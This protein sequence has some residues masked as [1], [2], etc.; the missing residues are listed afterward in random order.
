MRGTARTTIIQKTG[1]L[2]CI[3]GFGTIKTAMRICHV[4]TRMIVG[5][6]Q[7]NTLATVRGLAARGHEVTLISGPAEAEQG[8]LL[9]YTAPAAPAFHYITLP[10]LVRD[11]Q[12]ARDL[13]AYRALARHFGATPYDVIHTHSSKAGILGRLAARRARARGTRVVHTIHGLAFDAYQPWLLKRVYIGLERGC[14]RHTDKLVSVCDAMTQQALAAGVGTPDQYCTVYSGMDVA[15]FRA[16]RAGG[17]AWRARHGIAPD[18]LVLLCISRLFPMK[19]VEDFVDVVGA[20]QRTLPGQVVGVIVGDGPLRSQI[21]AQACAAGLAPSLVFA[22][23]VA[24]GEIPAWVG[25]ADALVHASLREGLARTLVQALAGGKP[26]FAYD[27]G[28]AREIVQQDGN[29][30]LA[31]AGAC[32]ALTAHVQRFVGDAMYRARV[33]AG[34]QQTDVARFDAAHMVAALEALYLDF[35]QRP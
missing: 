7:E 23:L 17:T 30:A 9:D 33:T 11:I 15:S 12:P 3:A 35:Q 4:I 16:A 32:A 34:A 29:G 28:G 1:V 25:A 8:A 22:G 19:G 26:V 6:A 18:A 31:P 13:A 20:A 27:I 14:A 21:E 2:L 24:P 5:G 10:H